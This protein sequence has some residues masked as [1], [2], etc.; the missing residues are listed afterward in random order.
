MNAGHRYSRLRR[1]LTP[2]FTIRRMKRLQPR[3]TEIVLANCPASEQEDQNRATCP[4]K[5]HE[6]DGSFIRS[7][8]RENPSLSPTEKPQFLRL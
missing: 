6:F 8:P 2:E 5:F 1:M 7:G 3:I 4:V